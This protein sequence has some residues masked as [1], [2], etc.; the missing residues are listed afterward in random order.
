METVF[1]SIYFII[2]EAPHQINRLFIAFAK[3]GSRHP[4]RSKNIADSHHVHRQRGKLLLQMT[5]FSN[6]SIPQ[7]WRIVIRPNPVAPCIPADCWCGEVHGL[8]STR[9]ISRSKSERY[10]VS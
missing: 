5:T 2:L 10:S 3:W 9:L 4:A 6:I 1:F 7:P 8:P